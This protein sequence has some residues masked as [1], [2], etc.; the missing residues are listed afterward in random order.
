VYD[1]EGDTWKKHR[2]INGG[3]HVQDI[4][5]FQGGLYAVG[6]GADLRTEFEAGQIFRYL[7][8]SGDKG[9]TFETVK[10]AE[11][12]TAGAGDTRWV[13]LCSTD[14]TLFLF[15]YESDFAANTASARNGAYDGTAVTDFAPADALG[16]VYPDGTLALPDGTCLLYGLAIGTPPT[17]YT[18]GIVKND[19]SYTPLDALSGSTV[20]DVSMS[21]TGEVVY[22]VQAG[23]TYGTTLTSWDLRV[24]VAD[25]ATPNA[26]KE[27]V[28]FTSSVL[29]T[30]IAGWSGMLFLGTEEG[31]VLRALPAP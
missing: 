30:A 21:E 5:S 20:L 1:L 6:S 29:P 2:T 22:L 24:L 10:R 31:K 4:A 23:D 18:A 9:Q 14:K 27:L 12:A 25:A 26:T 28:H 13:H 15:G 16:Q 8:H 3:E 7:W 19:A 17:H 11:V